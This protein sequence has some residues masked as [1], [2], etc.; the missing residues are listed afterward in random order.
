MNT[1]EKTRD[2]YF[3]NLKALLIF[4]VVLGHMLLYFTGICNNIKIIV[5]FIY[6]F[7][8][9]LF[10]FVT[11]YFSQPKIKEK[12]IF[13]VY[14]IPYLIF[15]FLYG[16]IYYKNIVSPLTPQFAYWYLLSTIIWKMAIKYLNRIKCIIPLSILIGVFAGLLPELSGYLSLGRT[17]MYLPFF[18]IGYNFKKDFLYKIKKVHPFY[19]FL[20]FI[21]GVVLF[22]LMENYGM[23]NYDYLLRNLS[24]NNLNI[25]Y[26]KGMLMSATL[27]VI[28]VIFCVFVMYIIPTKRNVFSFLGKNTMVI[29]LFH[30]FVFLLYNKALSYIDVYM[31]MDLY[32]KILLTILLSIL[33]T[34]VLGNNFF[35]NLY[36]KIENKLCEKFERNG[37][38]V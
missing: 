35:M 13:I 30:P 21:F 9:P 2:Y 32:L 8:M 4:L 11:G 7:H 36:K 1:K 27:F 25:I 6:V 19:I 24:Y 3:D 31:E 33:T 22:Y 26:Y 23:L 28:T 38:N 10:I 37:K 17:F 12:N 20:V 16:Y 29:F 14:L 5:D 34:I 18:V 15:N